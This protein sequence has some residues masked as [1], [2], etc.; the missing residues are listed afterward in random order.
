MSP[1]SSN[2]GF[3]VHP[4]SLEEAARL[5][6]AIAGD[7]DRLGSALGD[8]FRAARAGAGEPDLER[9][10]GLA[11]LDFDEFART[12]A[13]ATAGN[14]DRLRRASVDYV[15]TDQGAAA[16]VGGVLDLGLDPAPTAVT[17]ADQAPLRTGGPQ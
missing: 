8:A 4:I 12:A 5:L 16:A 14:A 9:C 10:L 13:T 15:T 1:S 6:E 7:M 11:A 3:L 17:R 2:G